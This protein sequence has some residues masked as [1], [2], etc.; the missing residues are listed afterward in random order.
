MVSESGERNLTG[1][2]I[3]KIE[4]SS[5]WKQKCKACVTGVRKVYGAVRK[6]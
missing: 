2:V 6:I 5:T 1:K 4:K 3:G